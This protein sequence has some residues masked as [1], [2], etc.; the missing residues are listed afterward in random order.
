MVLRFLAEYGEA[1]SRLMKLE[2]R[3]GN[4]LAALVALEKSR[5]RA[6]ILTLGRAPM[7]LHGQ[8][9]RKY[10]ERERELSQRIQSLLQAGLRGTT[11]QQQDSALRQAIAEYEVLLGEIEL[12]D[13]EAVRLRRPEPVTRESLQAALELLTTRYPTTLFLCYGRAADNYY[14]FTVRGPDGRIAL[15]DLANAVKEIDATVR[16]F[17]SKL[18]LLDDRWQS[19]AARLAH[20]LLL[21]IEG[22]LDGCDRIC[23]FPAGS[24]HQLPL[25]CLPVKDGA[26][27]GES[28]RMYRGHSFH[29][30]ARMVARQSQDRTDALIL[31]V[32][33]VPGFPPLPG[34]TAE[35]QAIAEILETEAVLGDEAS[36]AFLREACSRSSPRYLHL[37]SHGELIPASPTFSAIYL[38]PGGDFDGAL[39]V[40]EIMTLNLRGTELMALSAC[41]SGL[42]KV[43]AGEEVVG[44]SRA[45]AIAGAQRVLVS[46][47]SVAD[48]PTQEL[49]T[50]FYEGLKKGAS[51]AESLFGARQEIRSTT[52]HPREHR[53]LIRTG[54]AI[55]PVGTGL[56]GSHPY[57][58]ASFVLVGM[59]D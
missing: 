30:L 34:A 2:A 54:E 17:R 38:R 27:L 46:L 13:A 40:H 12:L 49:M 32:E 28:Y 11:Q 7:P 59:D 50:S 48:R 37:A 56:R 6:L 23:V 1:Y 24:L 20:R 25:A 58:W 52:F 43:G 31:G 3:K 15:V 42:G 36:E 51:P 57:F 29:H 44:L 18:F 41:E 8:G 22:Q 45:C 16:E 10:I 14:I 4:P 39:R 26:P 53:G 9:M 19:S 21:P 5:A 35:V 47:W 55:R 33:E